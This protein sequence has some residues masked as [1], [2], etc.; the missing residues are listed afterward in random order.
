M[1]L[2]LSVTEADCL[3]RQHRRITGVTKRHQRSRSV[4]R[5]SGL[6]HRCITD[7]DITCI[8]RMAAADDCRSSYAP[9]FFRPQLRYSTQPTQLD[10]TP[11]K[12]SRHRST[13]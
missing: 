10:H 1:I 13:E 11:R 2:L 4:Y 8:A 12:Q 6:V 9:A 7:I 5:A 3:D